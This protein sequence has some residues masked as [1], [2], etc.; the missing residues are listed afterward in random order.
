MQLTR[1]RRANLSVQ[2][3]LLLLS[4]NG[5]DASVCLDGT[6][7]SPAEI[8]DA[9]TTISDEQEIEI[10]QRALEHLPPRAGYG[11]RA[12][13]TFQATT[14]GVW[15]LAILS[16]S[17][18]REALEIGTRYSGPFLLSKLKPRDDGSRYVLEVDMHDLPAAIQRYIFE[19][20]YTTYMMFVRDMLPGQNPSIFEIHLPFQDPEYERQLASITEKRVVPGQDCFAVVTKSDWL[21]EPLPQADPIVHTHFTSQLQTLLK[22][23]QDLPDHAQLIRDHMI[24]A[25]RFSPR[26]EDVAAEAGLSSR[27]FRRRLQDEG[28]SF[29]EVVLATKMMIA[30]ELLSTAGLSVSSTAHRLGYSETSSFSRAF[31]RWW[32]QNPGVIGRDVSA[33]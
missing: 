10:L 7:L 33:T 26:L 1:H 12:A 21:D 17:R 32:G 19:R 24:D 15:G 11:I 25:N 30:K 20:V 6:G 18:V 8:L 13:G 27:S 2:A 22:S 5:I 16:S 23:Q 3:M 29:K 14:Y 31:S 28:T 4:E 9:E